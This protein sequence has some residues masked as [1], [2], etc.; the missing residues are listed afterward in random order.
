VP[1]SADL[2]NLIGAGSQLQIMSYNYKNLAS[3]YRHLR[4]QREN[5]PTRLLVEIP[6]RL[7]REDYVR[8]A[9]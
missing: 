5:L 3:T 6:G 2:E 9:D 1:F 7:I 8:I 4:K